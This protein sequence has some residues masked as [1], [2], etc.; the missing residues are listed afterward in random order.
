VLACPPDNSPGRCENEW[1]GWNPGNFTADYT[2]FSE[3]PR[4]TDPGKGYLTS[5]NNKQAPEYRA[6]D[7]NFS[8]G[9]VHRSEP[10]DDRIR[11]RISGGATMTLAE[12]VDAMEDA[13]TVDLRGDKVLPFMLEAL[14]P[15][16][17]R[18]GT[19][20]SKLRAWERAGAHRR[21]RS[22]ACQQD[23]GNCRYQHRDAIK[24]MD[25]WWP[26]A[27]DG[28][29]KPRLGAGLFSQVVDMMGIDDE[30]NAAGAHLGSAYIDCW[31]AYVEKDLRALLGRTV[32]DA[33]SQR[34]C[35]GGDRARCRAVLRSTLQRAVEASYGQ[36]Y[37]GDET[38]NAPENQRLDDQWCF[39]AI[40]H[41]PA[42]VIT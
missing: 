30:P 10:L 3:H 6:A 13:G 28:I 31:Y 22:S 38:C 23:R 1:R 5:W 24:I 21:D 40:E 12:L 33:F 14:G 18:L 35:G 36:T 11:P 26:R 29:F 34:Y 37:G 39:D 15:Q 4:A 8:Y 19:A 42:G 32:R 27:V 9:S 7:D 20:I 41:T 2:P 25:A 16:G 17:G